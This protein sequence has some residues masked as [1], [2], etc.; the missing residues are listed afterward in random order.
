MHPNFGR[1]QYSNKL[2]IT[3]FDDRSKEKA[4]SWLSLVIEPVTNRNFELNLTKLSKEF[5]NYKPKGSEPFEKFTPPSNKMTSIN[6]VILYN[7]LTNEP[8]FWSKYIRIEKS[9]NIELCDAYNSFISFNGMRTYR[10]VQIIGLI[11]QFMFFAKHIL[12][13]HDY[14]GGVNFLVNL[15]GA[16]DTILADFSNE[17]GE[18]DKKW[19]E[20]GARN[21]FSR[22]GLLDLTCPDLNLQMKY[23]LILSNINQ[24]SSKQTINDVADKLGLAYNHQSEPRCFNYNTDIFPWRQFFN[25][26]HY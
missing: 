15:I 1:N 14:N 20:P 24:Q 9:G 19:A 18:E 8:Q 21:Y 25:G 7:E 17:A 10:Y 11:W 3:N 12:A 2:G 26:Q 16:K 13:E 23:N 4:F 22:A 6:S 5:P